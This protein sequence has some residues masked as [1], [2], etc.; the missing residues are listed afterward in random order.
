MVAP[1]VIAAIPGLVGAGMQFAGA[2]SA[3]TLN[4]KIAKEQMK[5]QREQNERAM[6]FGRESS[7]MQMAFQERMSNTAY[8]R[9]MQDL[10]AAGLN[11]ILAYQQ[12]GASSPAGSS[13]QGVSSAGSSA[14]M[15]NVAAGA[16]NSAIE[17]K[18]SLAEF[19]NLKEQNKQIRSQTELNKALID[20][21][22][23]TTQMNKATTE[24]NAANAAKIESD[25]VRSWFDSIGDKAKAV[26]PW[27]ML[28]L[29]R[30]R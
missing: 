22:G 8:Q 13:A 21:S 5:F 15:Q 16:F 18:R 1:A 26:L 6:M 4:R 28:F 7:E 10:K 25:T 12:G 9:A 14:Q 23:S 3:N 30:G 24:Q 11:P 19:E 2:A 29:R 27:L 17:L 20:Q